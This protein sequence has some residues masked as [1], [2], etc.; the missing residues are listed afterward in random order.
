MQELSRA[1]QGSRD[2]AKDKRML[3]ELSSGASMIACGG[4]NIS[5]FN[6]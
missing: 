2:F 1:G 6:L 5:H 4:I 3:V